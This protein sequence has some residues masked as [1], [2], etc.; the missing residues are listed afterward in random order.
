MKSI[1]APL[2]LGIAVLAPPP[3][4]ADATVGPIAIKQAWTRVTPPGAKVAG[5]FMTITNT[6]KEADRLIGGTATIAGHLEVHEMSMDGGMMKMRELSG[7]LEIRP[8]QSVVL[9][10]GSYHVMFMDLKASLAAGAPVKGTLKFEKA[11]S[12]DI[13]YDVAPL[14]AKSPDDKDAGASGSKGANHGHH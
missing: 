11:G 1:V 10:P 7:G 8:G 3:F 2:A 13:S 14:G 9:K 6:G 5:G 4:A 12:V